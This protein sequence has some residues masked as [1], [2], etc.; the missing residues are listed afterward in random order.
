MKHKILVD[1]TNIEDL[2]LGQLKKAKEQIDKEIKWAKE[3]KEL[4]GVHN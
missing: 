2:S 1:G 3:E 4:I